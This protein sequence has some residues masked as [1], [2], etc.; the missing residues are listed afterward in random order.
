MSQPPEWMQP[1][2]D[3]VAAQFMAADVLAPIGCHFCEADGL[4]EITLFSSQTEIVGGSQD[5]GIRPSRFHLDLKNLVDVFDSVDSMY[6]QAQGLGYEDQLGPHVGIEGMFEGRRVWLRVLA[7][8]PRQ[9][10]PGRQAVV[11]DRS[12]RELW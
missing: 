3:Y 5:G 11:Q 12:W 4:W 1:L 8:P 10:P 9:F 2:A 6:W 7:I